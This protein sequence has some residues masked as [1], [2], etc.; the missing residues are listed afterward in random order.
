MTKRIVI[1]DYGLGNI[2]SVQRALEVSGGRDI[3]VSSR[4][5]EIITADKVIL[6]GVGAFEDGIRGLRDRGLVEC[7]VEIA[8]SGRPLL[9]IC[10]G[11]QLFASRSEEFGIHTGLN[12]IPGE[13]KALHNIDVDGEKLKVPFIGWARL[14]LNDKY[15]EF[16]CIHNASDKEVYFVHSFQFIPENEINL[17]GTYSLGGRE[18]TAAIQ[19]KNVVGLQFHPEKSGQVGLQIISDFLSIG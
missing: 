4:P 1:V 18:I 13:V 3:I 14:R 5:E 12:L 11:M 17:L 15:N 8:D 9:G 16:N 10:L 19:N 2:Y 6:P 7:I